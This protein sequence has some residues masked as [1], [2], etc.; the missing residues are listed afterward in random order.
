[1]TPSP[2]TSQWEPAFKPRKEEPTNKGGQRRADKEEPNPVFHDG[3]R[4]HIRI[5]GK[6]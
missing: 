5:P 6:V 4:E 2:S 1:M 3:E